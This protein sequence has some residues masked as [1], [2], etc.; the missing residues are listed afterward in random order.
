M[1][2]SGFLVISVCFRCERVLLTSRFQW[3][4]KKKDDVTADEND[5]FFQGCVNFGSISIRFNSG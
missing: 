4:I 2:V 1:F 5:R 3:T